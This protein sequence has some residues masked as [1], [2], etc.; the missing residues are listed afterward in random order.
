MEIGIVPEGDRLK[1]IINSTEWY[2]SIHGEF[3]T[4]Q[5]LISGLLNAG[6]EATREQLQSERWDLPD[7]IVPKSSLEKTLKEM[8]GH[9]ILGSCCGMA[10]VKSDYK[11]D[12]LIATGDN[13]FN[14]RIHDESALGV[15]PNLFFS[16]HDLSSNPENIRFL[17]R[18]LIRYGTTI[19]SSDTVISSF[20]F[21][22]SFYSKS[23]DEKFGDQIKQINEGNVQLSLEEP[24]LILV[25]ETDVRYK[26]GKYHKSKTEEKI[27]YLKKKAEDMRRNDKE[28]S[29][30]EIMRGVSINRK[31]LQTEEQRY[32]LVLKIIRS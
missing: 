15:K 20:P 18:T 1:D 31:R 13:I 6:W 10:G 17:F 28:K 21:Y 29:Y 11:F 24:D 8:C 7:Y 14:L 25:D 23:L 2:N 32:R 26:V 19:E 30:S 16:N 5:G 27:D 4:L 9:V 12:G 22:E 3:T